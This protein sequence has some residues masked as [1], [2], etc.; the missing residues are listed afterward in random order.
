M[1][2]VEG[3]FQ[4]IGVEF[5][6]GNAVQVGR[7]DGEERRVLFY[8]VDR[9]PDDGQETQHRVGVF[10]DV[11]GVG[12]DADYRHQ[13]CNG[14]ARFGR[15]VVEE[16]SDSQKLRPSRLLKGVSHRRPFGSDEVNLPRPRQH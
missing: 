6:A 2:C 14:R 11:I 12:A 4:P 13:R 7:L 3:R 1:E 5:C 9:P 10:V 15:S 8:C 16:V